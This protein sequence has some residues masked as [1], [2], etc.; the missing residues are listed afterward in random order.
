M[1]NKSS[2]KKLLADLAAAETDEALATIRRKGR[3]KALRLVLLHYIKNTD[4]TGASRHFKMAWALFI[5]GTPLRTLALTI[6]AM[7][8]FWGTRLHWTQ[9]RQYLFCAKTD[10]D[11]T[12]R[13]LG[14]NSSQNN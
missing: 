9:V 1:N 4:M 12:H 14:G 10:K 7:Q 13:L 3:E 2:L 8:D 6:D 5:A 11:G